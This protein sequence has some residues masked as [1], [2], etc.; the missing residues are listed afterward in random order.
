[1]VLTINKLEDLAKEKGN[2]GYGLFSSHPEPEERLKR[3]MK[4]IKKL[5]PHPDITVHEDGT[6]T[7][8]ESDWTFNITQT[9]GNDKPEYRAYMLAG[10]LYVARQRGPVDPYRFIVYDNGSSATLYY[11]DVQLLTVYNQ[12]AY[13]AGFG[14]AGSYANGCA[15]LLREWAPVANA[16]DAAK[17][18]KDKD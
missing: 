16:N 3:V 10:S 15:Q 2:P 18:D 14:D 11:E 8:H 7:V 17:A 5:D 4:Q 9:V 6:A 1:M 12:D 13:A